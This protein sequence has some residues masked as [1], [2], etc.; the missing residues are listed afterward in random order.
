MT[1]TGK[2]VLQLGPSHGVAGIIVGVA[3]FVVP[4]RFDSFNRLG[5]P[6]RARTFTYINGGIE[7][8]LGILA[9]IPR[10]RR[11]ARVLGL[12]YITYLTICIAIT[13]FRLRRG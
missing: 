2:R 12:C 10:T 13:Q 3:H 8:M 6:D 9:M 4:S 7:T 5:F 11:H 1:H